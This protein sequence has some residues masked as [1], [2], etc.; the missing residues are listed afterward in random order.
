[1]LGL[2]DL[3]VCHLTK[4]NKRYRHLCKII[5]ILTLHARGRTGCRGEYLDPREDKQQKAGENCIVSSL[6]ICTLQKM[7]L[8]LSDQE[9]RNGR[10]S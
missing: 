2:D 7:L 10:D 8:I 4:G 3:S 6:M 1:M 5:G 9:G